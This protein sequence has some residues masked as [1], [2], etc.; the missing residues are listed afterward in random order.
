MGE[1][2]KGGI[3]SILAGLGR[4]KTTYHR[5]TMDV[6]I[7]LRIYLYDNQIAERGFGVPVRL[8]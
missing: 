5:I 8:E 1:D 7:S 2:E 6:D 4:L 3:W